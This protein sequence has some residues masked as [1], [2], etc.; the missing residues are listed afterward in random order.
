MAKAMLKW[1]S[2]IWSLSLLINC[3]SDMSMFHGPGRFV[4]TN[5]GPNTQMLGTVSNESD[6]VLCGGYG[7]SGYN[8]ASPSNWNSSYF[9][10]Y[11][12]SITDPGAVVILLGANGANDDA[13]AEQIFGVV[14]QAQALWPKAV[15]FVQT[16]FKAAGNDFAILNAGLRARA[17]TNPSVV[18]VDQSGA[19]TALDLSDGLHPN[20]QGYYKL[21]DALIDA[22]IQRCSG[23]V[24]VWCL[25][26]SITHGAIYNGSGFDYE[27]SFRCRLYSALVSAFG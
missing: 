26:D 7:H 18:L 25:G 15:I 8:G 24:N 2:V 4:P 5:G 23:P 12:P 20:A 11:S 3:G 14:A 22:F 21:A 27:G 17:A 1:T 10:T 9:A 6:G 19:L 16:M 13:T